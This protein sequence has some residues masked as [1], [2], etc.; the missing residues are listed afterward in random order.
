MRRSKH[1]RGRRTKLST[2][3]EIKIVAK[4]LEDPEN[5]ELDSVELA[6]KLIAAL[7]GQREKTA[8]WGAVGELEIHETSTSEAVKGLFFV[9]PFTTELQALRAGEGLAHTSSHWA[10]RG[11][12]HKVPIV[13][14][15][16]SAWDAMKP[17]HK[18]V[19]DNVR[20]YIKA[21]EIAMFGEPWFAEK[22]G[23]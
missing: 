9:G 6:V 15:A 8:K 2:R 1:R 12:W 14:K 5:R 23:W 20:E 22:R 17:K 4:L 7:D 11:V 13:S 16:N 19:H 3:T 10:S 18:A 21:Q